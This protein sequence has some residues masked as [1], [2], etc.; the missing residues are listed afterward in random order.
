MRSTAR[1]TVAAGDEI[2]SSLDTSPRSAARV[3]PAGLERLYCVHRAD[4]LR[5][6]VARTGDPSEAEDVLQEVWFKLKSPGG[7]PIA[8]GRAFLYRVAHNLLV[9]RLRTRHRQMRRERLWSDQ[10]NGFVPAGRE[11]IDNSQSAEEELLEREDTA[12]LASVFAALPERARY[13]FVLHRLKG[14]RHAE[15]AEEMRISKSGV[16]KHMAVASK[17]F[18]RAL[19][20]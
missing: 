11:P 19:L 6:L 1:L 8:N 4:L 12:L 2:D 18:R 14:L 10:R 3:A 15:V 20:G 16:E 5:F 17:H 7:K 13:A 9:D